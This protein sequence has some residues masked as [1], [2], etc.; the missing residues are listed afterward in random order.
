MPGWGRG[1]RL[2]YRPSPPRDPSRNRTP[3]GKPK[4]GPGSPSAALTCGGKGERGTWAGPGRA[5]PPWPRFAPRSLPLLCAAA[6]S[7]GTSGRGAAGRDLECKPR[8]G[9][10]ALPISYAPPGAALHANRRICG[11]FP[12]PSAASMAV[13]E[14]LQ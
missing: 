10:G 14:H 2:C 1:H 3:C 4:P 5:E 13:I 7:L 11:L 8:S 9:G 6:A 12:L